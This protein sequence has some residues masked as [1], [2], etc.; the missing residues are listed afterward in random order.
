MPTGYYSD[1]A[2]QAYLRSILDT[3]ALSLGRRTVHYFGILTLPPLT[4]R[5]EPL[6]LY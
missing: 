5:F 1:D 2:K 3:N 6:V 4:E